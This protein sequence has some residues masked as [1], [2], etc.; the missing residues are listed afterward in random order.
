MNFNQNLD[1]ELLKLKV[2]IRKE[3]PYEDLDN[4]E[5]YR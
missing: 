2:A 4:D 1:S 5:N 3:I